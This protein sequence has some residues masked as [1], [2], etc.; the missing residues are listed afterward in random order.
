MANLPKVVASLYLTFSVAYDVKNVCERVK[1]V[2][3][4][5]QANAE[6]DK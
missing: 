5:K 1:S 4:S 6:S 3:E 2:S